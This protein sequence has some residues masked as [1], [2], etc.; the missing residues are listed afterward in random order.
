MITRVLFAAILAGIA[1]GLVMSLIQHAKVTPLILQ[2]ETYEAAEPVAE[3]GQAGASE[4]TAHSHDGDEWGPADGFE[5]TAFTVLSNVLAGTAFAFVLAGAAL[6]TGLPLTASN[7]AIWGLMGFL[8]FTL[9]PSAGLP[10]ELPGMP[11]ADL[12]I[13]QIWWWATVAA[14]GA[15]IAI[16]YMMPSWPVKAIGAAVIAIPHIVGAPHSLSTE[17][18]VPATLANS[19]AASSIATAAVFWV[20]LGALLGILM[21][22]S[23][24][25]QEA[26]A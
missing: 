17:T 15:G 4:A 6:L 3:T 12:T 26:S 16:I 14:T 23:I 24:T 9:A 5:R 2:A 20:V 18:D 13:R 21:S 19:F 1:A 10:P 11:A 7:G 22:R 25:A 8:A